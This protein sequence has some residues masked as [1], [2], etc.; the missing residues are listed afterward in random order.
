MKVGFKCS[1]GGIGDKLF[2]SA[3]PENYFLNTGNKLI[4]LDDVWC[5]D[6]NPY[7]TR[8]EEPDKIIDL[9]DNDTT[10]KGEIFHSAIERICYNLNLNVFLRHPRLYQYEDNIPQN[11]LVTVH[12]TGISSGGDL[13]DEIL[14][15]ILKRY[16]RCKIIQIGSKKDKPIK[17]FHDARGCDFWTSAEIISNS[18]VFIGPNSSMYNIALC[19]PHVC[20]KIILQEY[21]ETQLEEL[22]PLMS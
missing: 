12:T 20:K 15:Q 13:S 7:I 6:F 21:S 11:N 18:F 2:L 5:Y 10:V 8:N 3:L 16:S 14:D 22:F 4:D 19:Y 1:G 17:S 9:W